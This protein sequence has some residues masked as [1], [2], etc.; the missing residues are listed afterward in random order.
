MQYSPVFRHFFFS[1]LVSVNFLFSPQASFDA[2]TITTTTT[3]TTTTST[4]SREVQL[5]QGFEAVGSLQ[6]KVRDFVVRALE[7]CT[8]SALHV[9]DGSDMEYNRLLELLQV[10]GTIRPLDPVLRPGW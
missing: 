7:L 8:P 9:C 4:A 6:A 3:T 10:Q 5:I 1:P 2:A